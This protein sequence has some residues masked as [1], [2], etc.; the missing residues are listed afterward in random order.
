MVAGS[1]PGPTTIAATASRSRAVKRRGHRGVDDQPAGGGAALARLGERGAGDGGRRHVEVGVG[2]DHG[3][4]LAAEFGLQPHVPVGE[5]AAQ[6]ARR[7]RWT[8]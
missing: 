2:E 4:V 5:R 6:V 7:P 8:R 3:D 1:R